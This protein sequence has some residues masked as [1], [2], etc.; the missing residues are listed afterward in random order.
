MTA[1]DR[2][3]AKESP[4]HNHLRSADPRRLDKLK[5]KLD[6]EVMMYDLPPEDREQHKEYIKKLEAADAKEQSIS[7]REDA[8]KHNNG[9]DITK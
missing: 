2:E 4:N 1:L 8:H 6:A 9:I 7:V 3:V 5:A